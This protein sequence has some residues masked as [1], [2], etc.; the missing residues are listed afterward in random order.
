[1]LS[2]RTVAAALAALS[3]CLAAPAAAD[4]DVVQNGGFESGALTG[5][6]GFSWTATGESPWAAREGIWFALYGISGSSFA[7]G[8]LRQTVSIPRGPEVPF[9]VRLGS[10]TLRWSDRVDYTLGASESPPRYTVTLSTRSGLTRTLSSETLPS[11]GGT[12]DSGWRDHVADVSEF[13]GEEATLEFRV[14]NGYSGVFVGV[15]AVSLVGPDGC[16]VS[17]QVT[18]STREREVSTGPI[19]LP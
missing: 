2:T 15:D 10:A 5:W 4:T 3:L 8:T 1:M 17:E 18:V 12:G 6:G 13:L 9:V 19:C 16:V 11:E 7:H 14:R